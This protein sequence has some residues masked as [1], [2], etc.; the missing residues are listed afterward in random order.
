MG[1]LVELFAGRE[2]LSALQ[3]HG[4]LPGGGQIHKNERAPVVAADPRDFTRA[5]GVVV[6]R[7]DAEPRTAGE[8]LEAPWRE[9]E[10]E[11]PAQAVH[12]AEHAAG[13]PRGREVTHGS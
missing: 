10:V 2:H 3:S 6:R 11:L 1:L 13:P 7:R 9:I 8:T 12:L 5:H 4:L